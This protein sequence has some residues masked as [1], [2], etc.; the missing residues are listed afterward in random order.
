MAGTVLAGTTV[1]TTVTPA[2]TNWGGTSARR[3]TSSISRYSRLALSRSPS[4]AHVGPPVRPGGDPSRGGQRTVGST[5]GA[6]GF[7]PGLDGDAHRRLHGTHPG[8]VALGRYRGP[9]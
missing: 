6:D 1:V 5:P 4:G 3:R 9:A 2:G 7:G 8:L